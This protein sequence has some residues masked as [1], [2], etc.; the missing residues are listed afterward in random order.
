MNDSRDFKDA[1]SVPSGQSHVPSQPALLPLFRDPG[2]MLSRSLGMPSRNNGLPSIWDTHGTSGNVFANPTASSSAPYPQESN[3]WSSNASE[4]TS[5]HVMSESQTPAQDQRCQ[6]GPSAKILS[7]SVGE[8][9]LRIM[10]QTNNDC[11]FR[12]FTSTNSLHQQRSLVGRKDSRL[13]YVLAHSRILKYSTR[14]LL[15]TWTESSRISVS[16]KK[17]VWKQ[18]KLTKKTASSEEDKSLEFEHSQHWSDEMWKSKMAGGGGNKKIFQYCTDP[19]R[20]EI[21]YFRALQGHS[22]HN[23]IDPSL[24]DNVVLQSNFFP[25]H[26]S[27]RMCIQFAFYH[28][29][30]INTWR[31][32]FEQE[33]DTILSA[34]WSCGQKSQGSWTYRLLRTASRTNTCMKH[35]KDIKTQNIGSTSI[36]L[37]R[38]DWNFIRLDRM[39]SSFK[40]HFQFV[41]FRK[42]LGWKLEK[43]CTKKYTCHLGL[44]QR[45]LWNTNGKEIAFRT[46]STTRS[47][48]TI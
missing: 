23:L 33:T 18:W 4:H 29:F 38:K 37:L 14:E 48:A 3:P 47:W 26:I 32:K 21:I 44:N 20:Q 5:P 43:S 6:S 9:L 42:L 39:Q 13:R 27:C 8:T 2:G 12:N 11:R 19:S 40:K 1:E 34:C 22:G 28:Q 24:Q 31:S 10:V 16:R 46:C 41:V 25:I 36:L 45:F 30:G 35:G 17:S 15:K 7:S